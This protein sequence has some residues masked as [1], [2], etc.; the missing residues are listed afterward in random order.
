MGY[1][2][3]STSQGVIYGILVLLGFGSGL[4][5]SMGFSVS[6]LKVKPSDI[7]NVVSFQDICQ[8]GSSTIVLVIAGQ[9]FQS[10]ATA[11][12]EH[13]LARKGFSSA[14]IQGAVAG[15]QST[16]FKQLDAG[17]KL[18][19]ISAITE[20]IQRTFVLTIVGA[21]IMTLAGACMRVDKIFEARPT[22]LDESEATQLLL[23]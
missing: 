6:T 15:A 13:V 11:N 7:G 17:L 12:L 3:T 4:T 2:K 10:R 19:A 18:E 22:R 5:F 21:A 14:D 9:V 1:I 20:A 23:P 8:L 16:L